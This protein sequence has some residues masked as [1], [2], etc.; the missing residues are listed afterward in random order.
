MAGLGG[1]D[2]A[3]TGIDPSVFPDPSFEQGSDQHPLATADVDDR[4]TGLRRK[5]PQGGGK[6]DLL[7]II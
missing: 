5:H 2:Q 3:A 7:V 4:L 6:D 1:L